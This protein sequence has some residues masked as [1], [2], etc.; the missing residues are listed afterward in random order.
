[1]KFWECIEFDTF[2]E[3]EVFSFKPLSSLLRHNLYILI[4]MFY[5][6]NAVAMKKYHL[7]FGILA[8][9]TEAR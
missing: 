1:M 2:F 4:T 3:A 6:Q 8:D 5:L 7:S 9:K